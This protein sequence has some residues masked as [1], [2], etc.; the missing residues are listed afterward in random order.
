[1]SKVHFSDRKGRENFDYIVTVSKRVGRVQGRELL[2]NMKREEIIE[3]CKDNFINFDKKNSKNQIIDKVMERVD[4]H[5]KV[6]S[7]SVSFF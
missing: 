5:I 1:M 7:S 3:V 2:C 6:H 4:Y